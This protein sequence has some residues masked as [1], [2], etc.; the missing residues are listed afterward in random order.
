MPFPPAVARFNRRVTNPVVRI[1]ASRLP[2]LA[3]VVHRGRRSGRE[4]RTPVL[5]FPQEGGFAFAL[6]YGRDVDWLANVR[7]ADGC[8]LEWR[9][10]QVAL[11]APQLVTGDDG[12]RL[13]PPWVRPALRA[14]GVTEFVVMREP[15]S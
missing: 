4:Y 2:P 5:A 7:A 3:N 6:T 9:G 15:G 12:R 14:L 11:E 10:V 13:M 8:T 1:V